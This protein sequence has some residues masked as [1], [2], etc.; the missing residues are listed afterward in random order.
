MKECFTGSRWANTRQ[1]S[2]EHQLHCR[3]AC[4]LTCVAGTDAALSPRILSN[5]TVNQLSLSKRPSSRRKIAGL[6]DNVRPLTLRH[7]AAT[8]LMHR[9]VSIWQ[10]LGFLGMTL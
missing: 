6:E 9:G 5:E 7:T 2:G 1:K 8:W 3:R 4:W 10:A